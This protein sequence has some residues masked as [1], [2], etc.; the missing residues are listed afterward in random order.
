MDEVN[1]I[2]DSNSIVED[3]ELSD[4]Q[5][6]SGDEE[7]EE[8]EEEDED[9]DEDDE[10][11][12]VD[13]EE[14]EE[15]EEGDGDEDEDEDD[16]ND[17]EDNGEEEDGPRTN[18]S[19]PLEKP[20]KSNDDTEPLNKVHHYYLSML[21][22]A[23]MSNTYNIYPTAAIPIQAHVHTMTMSTG[24]KY[25]FLGGSDGYIRKYDFLNTLQGKLSLT[26]IQRHQLTESVSNAGILAGYWENEIPQRRIDLGNATDYQPKVSPVYSLAVEN[27]CNYILS[28][29]ENGGVTMMGVRYMEGSIGHYFKEHSLPVNQLIINNRQDKFISGSWDRR[30]I[31]WDLQS[32][33]KVSNEFLG[34]NSEVSSMSWRPLFSSVELGKDEETESLFGEEEDDDDEEEPIQED[35]KDSKPSDE[36]CSQSLKTVRDENVLLSSGL[37]GSIQLWDVRVSYKPVASLPRSASTPPWCMSA[38]WSSDGDTIYAGR[39]NASIE[40]YSLRKLTSLPQTLKL[41]SLSGPV[42]ALH[43]MPNGRHL[44]TASRDNLRLCE[45]GDSKSGN[46]KFLIVPG[47]HGGT[48]SQLYVDPS[49]RFLVSLSGDRGWRL[50]TNTGT[51]LIYDIDLE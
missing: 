46:A 23:K 2:L 51:V 33:G 14:E 7:P 39:R 8:Q 16:E 17:D 18:T 9:E 36:I 15:E 31:E 25:M 43:S 45:I 19:F 28:G 34:G 22:S 30:I 35:N 6:M 37:N 3:E 44:L 41:P 40:E 49:N 5:E 27:E 24:L 42:T 11:E 1:D 21:Q 47:H 38:E 20:S 50:G 26:I 29:L 48:I 10:D 13:D 32:G 12:D 4:D